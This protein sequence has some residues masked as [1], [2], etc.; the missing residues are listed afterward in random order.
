VASFRGDWHACGEAA[1][2]V[3]EVADRIHGA[4]QRNMA[5]AL[6]G[7]ALFYG[8]GDATGIERMRS[9]ALFLESRGIG[10][11]LSWNF[12]C[13]AEALLIHGKHDEAL[14][15]A[16]TALARI[17]TGD[18]IG[19]ASA[20]R[21]RALAKRARGEDASADLAGSLEA[22]RDKQSPREELVTRLY[23][24]EHAREAID[25]GCAERFEQWGMPWYAQRARAAQGER[26]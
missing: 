9:A 24:S 20:L 2:R 19:R 14:A 8:A 6:E 7:L 12:A 22:A 4:Y 26:S 5:V 13:L 17:A 15:H 23:W 3:R 11:T 18:C 16:E 1:K 25:P 21:V 10:L